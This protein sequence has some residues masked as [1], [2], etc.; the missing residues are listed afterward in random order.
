MLFFRGSRFCGQRW[1]RRHGL[2][3]FRLGFREIVGFLF[4]FRNFFSRSLSLG[5]GLGLDGFGADYRGL[6]LNSRLLNFPVL[7]PV[8]VDLHN[9][10]M[11]EVMVAGGLAIRQDSR[12]GPR[13]RDHR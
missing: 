5:F 3:L 8:L 11:I 7:L 2:F 9:G 1:L 10:V 12:W 6:L 13:L 4:G